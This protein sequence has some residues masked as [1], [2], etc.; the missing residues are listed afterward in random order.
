[1]RESAREGERNGG[2]A[3]HAQPREQE[4][5]LMLGWRDARR[6]SDVSSAPASPFR[7]VREARRHNACR[8]RVT[9]TRARVLRKRPLKAKSRSAARV[10]RFLVAPSPRVSLP[11]VYR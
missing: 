1:M 10:A 9:S 7:G 8:V 6:E 4:R 11:S 5:N 2:H 3:S